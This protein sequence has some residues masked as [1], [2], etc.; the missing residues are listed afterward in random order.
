M[1]LRI[2]II[3]LLS[4]CL[5]ACS[6]GGQEST[7]SSTEEESEEQS[8]APSH[9]VIKEYVNTPKNKAKDMAGKVER[10]QDLAKEQAQKLGEE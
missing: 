5:F 9:N 10:A 4:L 2:G 7:N 6:G 8:D 3:L 1:Y